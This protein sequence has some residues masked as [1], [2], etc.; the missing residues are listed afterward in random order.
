MPLTV[1]DVTKEE[2]IKNAISY[3]TDSLGKLDILFN[4][5]GGPVELVL[6]M[7]SKGY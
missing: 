2:D 5:A 4:N 1:L 6:R 7:Y 3:T